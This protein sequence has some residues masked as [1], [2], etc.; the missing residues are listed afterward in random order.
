MT[1]PMIPPP[2]PHAPGRVAW[3]LRA[4]TVTVLVLAALAYAAVLVLVGEDVLNDMREDLATALARD[5]A[6]QAQQ[7]IVAKIGQEL[8]LSQRLA[9]SLSLQDWLAHEADPAKRQR[10]FQEGEN[11]RRAFDSQSY[12]VAPLASLTF[13]FAEARS[14]PVPV[15]SYTI[16]RGNPDNAWFFATLR[17]PEGYWVNVD[18]DKTIGVTNVWI[19]VAARAPDGTDRGVVGTGIDLG[20][21]LVDLLVG[22]EPGVT[23]MIVDRAGVIVAH[24]DPT[25]MEFNLASQGRVDKTLF[26]LPDAEAEVAG[27][28]AMLDAAIAAPNQS[29]TK[30]LHIDGKPRILALAYIPSLN[31]TVATLVDGSVAG[32]LTP[33]H[34]AE[35]VSG[36]CLSLL[37]LLFIASVGFERMVLRPLTALTESVRRIGADAQA[38]PLDSARGD[39]IGELTRAFAEMARRVRSHSQHLERMVDA[40]T[41][42]L[43]EANA[44]M[45][46]THE[47]LTDSIRYA[48]LIQTAI[49]PDRLLRDSFR[50]QY[51]VL[52]R[53]RDVVGGDLYVYRANE[54]GCLFGV[55]DCAGHGVPGACMTMI[56]HAALE[57]ALRD[58]PWG[59]PAALLGRVDAAARG[60]L[61]GDDRSGRIAT[62][63]DMGLVHV[64]LRRHEVAFA[65]ARMGLFWSDGGE[66]HV[67]PGSRRGLNDRKPG[68]YETSRA[69]L[70]PGRTF[71]L[72][73]DGLLDQ[74]GGEQGFGF[75]PRRFSDW[76]AAHATLPL[77]IQKERLAETLDLYRGEHGQR[78]DITVLAFRFED[79]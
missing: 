35:G 59:D 27:V 63:M 79:L 57:V 37:A 40:R 20:R 74:S 32:A 65:G 43:A 61:P 42:D 8:A 49:L 70:R 29:P 14:A 25:R 45:R 10:F 33:R 21:F 2:P 76:V 15:A 78:D 5:T 17:R 66:C 41:S 13:Y 51:F 60:I 28:R 16:R 31:W 23:T 9:E 26:R 30:R 11:F 3:G 47:K 4:R 6:H 48:S 68:A 18:T 54:S 22:T 71:Y 58:A 24:P 69:E 7:R 19:N 12:F 50:G 62:N 75:G 34:I 44:R 56:A 55:V 36:I 46:E 38:E 1:K 39:E 72:A 67:L 73:S 77:D 64:D 53:P 52:W